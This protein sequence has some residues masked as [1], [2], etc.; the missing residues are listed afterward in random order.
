M[1]L[2]NQ[3]TCPEVTK[4]CSVDEINHYTFGNYA[5]NQLN[6]LYN[7]FEARIYDI[8]EANKHTY[9]DRE[10]IKEQDRKLYNHL[11]PIEVLAQLIISYYNYQAGH[12][13]GNDIWETDDKIRALITNDL[14]RAFKITGPAEIN[15][16]FTPRQQIAI[17]DI[18]KAVFKTITV[19]TKIFINRHISEKCLKSID[20]DRKVPLGT[21]Y[22]QTVS[23]KVYQEKTIAKP[24]PYTSGPN[25]IGVS[26]QFSITPTTSNF[27]RSG[28]N[29][30]PNPSAIGVSSQFSITPNTQNFSRSG[31]NA[32]PNPNAI[33]VSSQF[34]LT[35]KPKPKPK[36]KSVLKPLEQRKYPQGVPRD[37]AD[38]L[39]NTIEVEDTD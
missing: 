7:C 9:T 33:G 5:D 24:V 8:L 38:M 6:R 12:R 17:K 37:H 19:D 32:I 28:P 23:G 4:N 3:S 39:Y 31:P 30:I 22:K 25:A 13:P 21:S 26:S 29:A 1:A 34:S 20:M 10:Q 36:L 2:H 16:N 27:S 15:L 35:P 11:K 14:N 18:I